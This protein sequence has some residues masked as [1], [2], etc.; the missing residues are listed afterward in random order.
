MMLTLAQIEL[1]CEISPAMLKQETLAQQQ[2]MS[3][4]CL[5]I[6]EPLLSAAFWGDLQNCS[7]SFL[8]VNSKGAQDE[9]LKTGEKD[10]ADTD[11][12]D[13]YRRPEQIRKA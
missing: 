8:L 10:F 6:K 13:F 4:T 5:A 9:E 1:L 7:H 11:A 2:H 12:H 3:K